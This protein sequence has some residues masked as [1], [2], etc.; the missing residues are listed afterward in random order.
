VYA[1][2][3]D[4]FTNEIALSLQD[5]PAGF[6]LSGAKIPAGQDQVRLTLLAPPS[7][8]DKPVPVSLEGRAMI[9]GHAVVH[10]AVPAEDMMQAFA[11]RHLVPASELDVVVSGR[12][13]NRVSLRLLSATPIR[14]PAGGTARVLV[15][16]PARGMVDRL[17]LELSDPPEGITIGKVAAVSEGAEIEVCS[18]AAK[19]KPGLKGNLIV[20]IFQ[21]QFLAAAAKAKKQ[22]SQRRAAVGTLPAIPFEIVQP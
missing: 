8:T 16:T 12:F 7:P 4:G 2:R 20:N 22:G 10:T 13:M 17:K 14:I 6:K 19:A 15:S 11:Y 21:G 18:D 5:A 1:L 3:R 9:Q